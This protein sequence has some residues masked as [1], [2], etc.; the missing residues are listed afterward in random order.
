MEDIKSLKSLL[1]QKRIDVY[2]KIN[3]ENWFNEYKK[4]IELGKL[5]YEKLHFL[6]IFLRNKIDNEF[7]KVFGNDWLINTDKFPFSHKSLIKINEVDKKDHKVSNLSFGFWSSLFHP[8]YHNKIWYKNRDLLPS[9]FPLF[10]AHERSLK[11]IEKELDVI[12]KLRNR[13]FHF[14]PLINSNTQECIVLIEKYVRGL[15]G[16]K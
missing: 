7:Q 3:Q 15:G 9:V 2:R 5:F 13:V 8:Y 16:N 12:R 10:K 14:E 4:D 6:E 1:S 11:H